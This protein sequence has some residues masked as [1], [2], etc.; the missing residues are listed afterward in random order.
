MT[1]DKLDKFKRDY[2]G[3][4]EELADLKKGYLEHEGDMNLVLESVMLA[5]AVDDEERLRSVIDGWIADG[6]V[7]A[8]KAY[9]K[10]KAKDKK[11]RRDLA[12]REAAEADELRREIESQRRPAAGDPTDLASMILAR[13]EQRGSFFDQFEAKYAQK[14]RKKVAKGKASPSELEEPSEEEFLAAQARIDARRAS[15]KRAGG[16]AGGKGATAGKKAKKGAA[17]AKRA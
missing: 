10:E 11:K 5:N 15:G 2:S 6:S 7:P 14:A 9:T 8:F 16:A 13:R 4:E 17:K 1:S 3:S 12:S